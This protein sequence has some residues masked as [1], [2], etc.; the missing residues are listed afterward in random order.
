MAIT[1]KKKKYPPVKMAPYDPEN[2]KLSKKDS[3]AKQAKRRENEARIEKF[4]K[5]LMDENL[6]EKGKESAL[7]EIGVMEEK[8]ELLIGEISKAEAGEKTDES[9]EKIKKFKKEVSLLRMNIGKAKKAL[10]TE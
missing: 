7:S 10:A 4:R 8:I 2:L 1:N 9:R 5:E 6:P 3:V